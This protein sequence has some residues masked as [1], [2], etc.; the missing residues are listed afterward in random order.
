M[1]LAYFSISGFRPGTG[2][3]S[4]ISP[5]RAAVPGTIEALETANRCWYPSWVPME[6]VPLAEI[7]G[8]DNQLDALPLD[9]FG[10]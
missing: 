10:C 2:E 3:P 4:G 8:K 9:R 1:A 7:W 6:R 5:L